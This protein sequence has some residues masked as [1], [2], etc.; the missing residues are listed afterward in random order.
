MTRQVPELKI[1]TNAGRA[2]ILLVEDGVKSYFYEP[3]G[4]DGA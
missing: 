1:K 2:A 4:I 3:A